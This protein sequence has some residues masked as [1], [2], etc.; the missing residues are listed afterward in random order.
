[1]KAIAIVELPDD[2]DLTKLIAHVNIG[3]VRDCG[4]D[5]EPY[6]F[7]LYCPLRPLPNREKVNDGSSAEFKMLDEVWTSGFNACLDEMEGIENDEDYHIQEL[8]RDH[9]I[10]YEPTYN[11]EDGSL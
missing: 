11:E 7:R 2:A 5:Y 1:M 4:Y 3:K 6:T 10:N 9:C 8:W